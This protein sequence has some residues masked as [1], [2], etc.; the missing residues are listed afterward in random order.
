MR[1]PTIKTQYGFSKIPVEQWLDIHLSNRLEVLNIRLNW[2]VIGKQ[3]KANPV[4]E[5]CAKCPLK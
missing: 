3:P 2:F 4:Q 5:R 1:Y